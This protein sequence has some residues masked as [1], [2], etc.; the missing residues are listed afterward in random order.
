MG[1]L[2][3]GGCPKPVF[4][5]WRRWRDSKRLRLSV[6]FANTW[7]FVRMPRL[8]QPARMDGEFES[9]TDDY[10]KNKDLSKDRSL[11]WRRWRDSKRLRLSVCFANTWIFVRM[12]RLRQPARMDG[13]FESLT[14]DYAKTKTCQKTGL[15]FGGDGETRTL[16]PVTRPTPLAGAPRHQL[17]YISVL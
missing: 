3:Y 4:F 17:E 7:I 16:A 12:P 9:L 1:H 8:R 5:V 2:P 11:F 10:T 13:S 14:D 6:C 15:Y